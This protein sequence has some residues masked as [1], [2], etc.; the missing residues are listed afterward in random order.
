VVGHDDGE[1]RDAGSVMS[2]DA[3]CRWCNEGVTDH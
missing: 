3:K 1:F 2:S